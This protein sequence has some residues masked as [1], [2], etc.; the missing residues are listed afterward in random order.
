MTDLP[1]LID[2]LDRVV[3]ASA[4]VVPTGDMEHAAEIATAA[5]RRRGYLGES[6]LVALAGGTGSGKSSLLNAVAG[7]EV[8]PVG[9]LRPTTS[10]PLA[11]IPAH[12]EPGLVRL[13]DDLGIEDRVGQIRFPW[14]AIVDL[15]DTDS[16][17]VDHRHTVE[18]LLPRIDAV[19]WVVDPEKYQDRALHQRYLRPLAAHAD[20]FRFVLNQC[21][22]L[23]RAT[24]T[25]VVEDLEDGLRRDGFDAPIV[26][27]TAADPQ[28]GPPEG[29][30][31]FEEM[32][33]GTLDA[34]QTVT[35]K[36][37]VDLREAA[38]ALADAGLEA[39]GTGFVERWG[40]VADEAAAVVAEEL[41]VDP[42]TVPQPGLSLPGAERAAQ[43]IRRLLDGVGDVVPPGSA[44]RLR[45]ISETAEELV[46][47]AADAAVDT[48]GLR[49]PSVPGWWTVVR[50]S[51]F[52]LV[53]FSL[54]G[55]GWLVGAIRAGDPPVA[56]LALVVGPALVAATLV[57]SHRRS[58]RRWGER[59]REARREE[60]ATL[61]AA[62]LDRRIGR[63]AREVLRH[64]AEAAAALTELRLELGSWDRPAPR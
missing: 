21:D 32:L 54:V 18:R 28:G 23:D 20:R 61:V 15:P 12:P 1:A 47:R 26:V 53:A 46:R 44:G 14:L 64:R 2:L 55:I 50:T 11:W 41:S 60:L 39:A 27:A 34:K 59:W 5:R 22:R 62:E 35:R 52:V 63:P 49:H 40:A 38:G 6:L 42:V 33:L 48:A 4:G 19:V 3:A 36:L 37:V 16:V 51:V 58:R 29:L 57:T 24:L 30:D 31:R 9:A 45:A 8:A 10:R 43:P 7:E 17:V 56:P 13:L 25:R